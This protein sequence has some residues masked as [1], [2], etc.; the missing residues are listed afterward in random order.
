MPPTLENCLDEIIE[1]IIHLLDLNSIRALCQTSRSLASKCTQRYFTT[2]YLKKCV[3]LQRDVLEDFIAVTKDDG[4]VCNV[5]EL[6]VLGYHDLLVEDDRDMDFY[7]RWRVKNLKLARELYI[8][9]LVKAFE[10]IKTWNRDGKLAELVLEVVSREEVEEPLEQGSESGAGS[11]EKVE[12]TWESLSQAAGDSFLTVCQSLARS[13]LPV[14]KISLFYQGRPIEVCGALSCEYLGRVDWE[15]EGLAMCFAGLLELSIRVSNRRI[16]AYE[17][18]EEEDEKIDSKEHGSE[19]EEEICVDSSK[20]R[21]Y[22]GPLKTAND[23]EPPERPTTDLQAEASDENNFTGLA[24]LL[25]LCP[26]LETFNLHNYLHSNSW[27]PSEVQQHYGR[28]FQRTI[29]LNPPLLN[30]RSCTLRGLYTEEKYLLAFLTSLGTLH[31]ISL[32]G[33]HLWPG[34]YK[35]I[36]SLFMDPKSAISKLFLDDLFEEGGLILF[37]GP[38][39]PKFPYSDA[40]QG[41]HTLERGGKDCEDNYHIGGDDIKSPISYR[42]PTGGPLGSPYVMEWRRQLR[43]RYGR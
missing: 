36:F 22:G 8:E 16:M 28:L 33:V 34:T 5:K 3:Q 24:N 32:E 6:V 19:H 30:V 26:R 27:V 17:E 31:S 18:V 23:I 43:E 20:R 25:R 13:R 7:G 14:E 4:L 29:E 42:V 12:Y 11:V 2:F 41:S 10:S 21:G 37:D 38:G 9:L 40:W 35:S 1:E 15:D 39:L